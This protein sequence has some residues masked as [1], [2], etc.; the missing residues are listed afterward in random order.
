MRFLFPNADRADGS[1][2]LLFAMKHD[3]IIAQFR[4]ME[5]FP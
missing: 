2:L 5:E 4:P 1:A 3:T